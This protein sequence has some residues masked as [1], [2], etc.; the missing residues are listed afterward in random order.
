M[1]SVA[2]G[3]VDLRAN[4]PLAA[5][6]KRYGQHVTSCD[7]RI[8]PRQ[9]K[10][11]LVPSSSLIVLAL[12]PTGNSRENLEQAVACYEQVLVVLEERSFES[13]HAQA[14]AHLERAKKRLA[15]IGVE[16]VGSPANR[17]GADERPDIRPGTKVHFATATEG[18]RLLSAR[19]AFVR[20]MSPFDRA[21]RLKT[22]QDVAEDEYLAFAGR[23]CSIGRRT[24]NRSCKR[25]WPRFGQKDGGAGPALP[26]VH[27][28]RQDDGAGGG[29]RG[30]LPRQP[31]S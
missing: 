13:E 6:L 31:P 21:A 16:A 7:I 14:Q 23:Q 28:T 9:I 4:I 25:S 20:A 12:K 5:L 19:D 26:S 27:T 29:R 24:K 3:A 2:D 1:E 15:E 18:T 8:V 11:S 17:A 22:D 10:R 30:L